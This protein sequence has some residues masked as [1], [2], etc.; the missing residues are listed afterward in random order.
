MADFDRDGVPD[1]AATAPEGRVEG[2][3]GRDG[4][5]LFTLWDGAIGF[6]LDVVPAPGDAFPRLVSTYSGYGLFTGWQGV[7]SFY[8]GRTLLVRSVP[9]GTAVT[10]AGCA[11]GLPASPRIGF[12]Q[13]E[14]ADA[15]RPTAR[16]L[17]SAAPAGAAAFLLLG[18]S[19]AAFGAFRLPLDLGAFG[20]PG[21]TLYTSAEAILPAAVGAS[22]HASVDVPLDLA[23]QGPGTFPLYAQW[24]VLAPGAGGGGMSELLTWHVR[25]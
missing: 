25:L 8:R 22:G 9:R 5:K 24:K 15:A 18:V 3:S 19:D 1:V 12:R 21:C 23:A 11:R 13:V 17:V 6:S 2:F 14:H 16:V 7:G 20:W 10:G 4:A